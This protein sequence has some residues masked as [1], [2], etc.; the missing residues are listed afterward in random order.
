M[1]NLSD[2]FWPWQQC[3]PS[4][5]HGASSGWAP[6]CTHTGRGCQ[7]A[8]RT[9]QESIPISALGT[10]CMLLHTNKLNQVRAQPFLLFLW[11]PEPGLIADSLTQRWPV[12]F[13]TAE[14]ELAVASSEWEKQRRKTGKERETNVTIP[15]SDRRYGPDPYSAELISPRNWGPFTALSPALNC[16]DLACIAA[17]VWIQ[18]KPRSWSL[19]S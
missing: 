11:P 3:P 10:L 4:C 13:F 6:S 17:S 7:A 18:H 12:L 5:L 19:Q 15:K 1:H 9:L 16:S 2:G 8:A 14:E